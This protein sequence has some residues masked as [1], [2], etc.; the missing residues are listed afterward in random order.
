MADARPRVLIIFLGLAAV[1]SAAG[2]TYSFKGGSVPPHL[3][4]LAIAIV[5]DQSGYGDPRLRDEFTNTLIERFTNDN[6]LTLVD[7]TGADALLETV[8]TN[9]RE[10]AVSVAPGEEV[11]QRRMTVV[12][13]AT[14]RD[15]KLKKT[16]W[17][18]SFSQYGDF[19]SGGGPSLRDAGVLE[20]IQKI[21]ED[22]LNETVAGW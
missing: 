14:F 11:R 20:A 4:T 19:P 22:I 13:R 10:E 6:T 17:E 8:I 18:K 5:Q 3:K 15:N 2:C 12:A 9:V 1:V 7:Q 16:L 21:T